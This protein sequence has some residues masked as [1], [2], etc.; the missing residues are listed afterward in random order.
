[1][2]GQVTRREFSALA[3]RS[4]LFNKVVAETQTPLLVG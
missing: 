3:G 4:W 1:M 2:T